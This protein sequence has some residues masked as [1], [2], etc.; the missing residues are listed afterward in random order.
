MNP[1]RGMWFN[2]KTGGKANLEDSKR[3]YG[4]LYTKLGFYNPLITSDKLVLKNWLIR[5]HKYW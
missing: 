1:R 4:Y 2:L 5:T 3:T